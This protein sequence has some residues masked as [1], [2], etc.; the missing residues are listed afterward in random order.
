MFYD[1]LSPISPISPALSP[2]TSGTWK[3]ATKGKNHIWSNSAGLTLHG[4]NNSLTNFLPSTKCMQVIIQMTQ[5]TVY[6]A[7]KQFAFFLDC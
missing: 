3:Q 7:E 2:L 6:A 1:A 4:S 5:A